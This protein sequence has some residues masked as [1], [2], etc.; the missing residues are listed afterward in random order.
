MQYEKINT[1]EQVNMLD[2]RLRGYETEHFAHAT[3]LALLQAS[4][5]Q[6][7]TTKKAIKET[8]EAMKTLD[9][10]HA[11]TKKEIKKLSSSK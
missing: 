8:E 6:D 9:E 10:A 5:T 11:N 2:A 4:A 3:N 1:N 7:E